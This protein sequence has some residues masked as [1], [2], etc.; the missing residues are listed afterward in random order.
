MHE[1]QTHRHDKARN[2]TW[3][4]VLNLG[5][6][7]VEI[8]GGLLTNSL[9]IL[10]DALHDFGDSL[11]LILA[12]VAEKKAQTKPD[13]K[14][15][16]GYKRLTL[17]AA[18][19]TSIVLVSGSLFI[20]S[21]A[22]PRLFNPQPVN[23]EGMVALAIIGIIFNGLGFLK[24][25]SGQSLNQKALTWHLLEDVLGWIVVLVGSVIM[26]FWQ[27]PIIDPLMTIGY[28]LFILWGV[29][30]NL[31]ENINILLQG[32]PSHIDLNHI[33]E[34]LLK[35]VEVT[36]VHDM[37]V[38][39]LDGETDI[40]TGHIVVQDKALKDMEVTKQRIKTELANHHIEHSTLELESE[41][42]CAGGACEHH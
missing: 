5:F 30:K 40:F 31:K 16:F 25:K 35:L 36:S 28:T 38:W 24:L 4:I 20:L 6:T 14:R 32:V 29:S 2:I 37:H 12:W 42:S 10:S 21:Q 19:I 8:I 1:H 22:I 27:N 39:S 33:Q 15:T 26:Y 34:G 3:A 11:V 41:S 18:L 7:L 23:A 13:Q 17:G 9:T